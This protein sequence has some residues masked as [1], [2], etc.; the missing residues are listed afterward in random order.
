MPRIIEMYLVGFLVFVSL[1]K[2]QFAQAEDDERSVLPRSSSP[3]K[4]MG[5]LKKCSEFFGMASARGGR[6]SFSIKYKK[7]PAGYSRQGV[8]RCRGI[9]QIDSVPVSELIAAIDPNE[10]SG[11]TKVRSNPFLPQDKNGKLFLMLIS[12]IF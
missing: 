8:N 4:R 1:L 12:P 11:R 5:T 7:C 2:I 9:E 6:S 10:N 3:L